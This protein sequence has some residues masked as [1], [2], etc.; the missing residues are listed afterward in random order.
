MSELKLRP[1]KRRNAYVTSEISPG[2]K[3]GL[4]RS[5]TTSKVSWAVRS[6]VPDPLAAFDRYDFGETIGEGFPHAPVN[7]NE[8]SGFRWRGP[9][10]C[11]RSLSGSALASPG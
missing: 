10:S 8:S 1:P 6:D 11:S 2:V 5:L 7:T 4:R 9:C 3:L